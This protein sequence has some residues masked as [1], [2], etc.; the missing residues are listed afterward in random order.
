VEQSRQLLWD[1]SIKEADQEEKKAYKEYIK[2]DKD[3]ATECRETFLDGLVT[4]LA[5]E[6]D[7]ET[8]Y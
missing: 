6:G 4:A 5:K 2:F 3:K 1:I 7:K 8:G